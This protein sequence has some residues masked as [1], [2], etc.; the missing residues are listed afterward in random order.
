M[1]VARVKERSLFSQDRLSLMLQK[2]KTN[3]KNYSCKN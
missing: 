3:L 2:P 1:P